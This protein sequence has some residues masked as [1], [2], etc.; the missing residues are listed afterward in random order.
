MSTKKDQRLRF[1]ALIIGILLIY[2]AGKWIFRGEMELYTF[3]TWAAPFYNAVYILLIISL[4][5]LPLR[6]YVPILSLNRIELLAIYA[7]VSVGSALISSDMQ[8]ILITLMGYPTYF[9][10]DINNWNQLFSGV[11]PQ[12]LTVND[13]SVLIGFYL[14]NSSF[15]TPEH[16]KAWLKPI[17]PW[18]LFIWALLMM[19]MCVNAILRK[20]WTDRERLTFPIV[21]L[22]MAMAGEPE[23]FFKNK[24]MWLGFAIAGG[25]TLI[26]GLNYLYPSIPYIPIKRQTFELATGGP[27]DA[28][29]PIRISFYFFGITLGFLMPLDLSF[30]LYLFYFLFKLQAVV[31]QILGVPPESGFPYTDSQAFGAYIAIFCAAIW[32]LK[33][34]L[35]NVWNTAIGRGD[36]TADDDEPMRYRWAI[37]GFGASSIFLVGFAIAAGISPIVAVAFFLVYIAL[38][39]MITRIRA[40]FG[41]PVHDMHHMG[42]GQTMVRLYGPGAFDKETLGAFSLFYWFNRVYRSHPMPHQL[43]GMKAAGP[44]GESQRSMMR[45]MLIAGMVAVPVCFLVY[46]QGFY[47]NGAATANINDWGI[48]YGNQ[49]IQGRLERWLISPELPKMGERFATMFGFV[50]AIVLAAARRQFVGFPLHPLSYAVANSWG[51]YNLWLPIMVGSLCKTG[52]LRGMGLQ[53]YRKAVMLFFGLMLGEFAVGCSWTILGMLMDIRTYDFWP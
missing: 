32:G 4:L 19:L 6:K 40:E 1:R 16:M 35:K 30:S 7:M 25:I 15:F 12:W 53:G 23:K 42:P 24:L 29:N 22:P 26:N 13:K 47:V 31:V 50:F 39:V 9:A 36:Q 45:V 51:M 41:F 48:G 44:G 5:N 33:G 17:I 11:L 27:L 3:A 2:L 49:M 38:S 8:G 10:N 34:H 18:T 14:G 43:E 46:L 37:I 21:A 20:A 52:V 28:L